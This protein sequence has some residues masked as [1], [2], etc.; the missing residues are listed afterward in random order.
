MRC[1]VQLGELH[2]YLDILEQVHTCSYCVA[3]MHNME[4]IQ[5]PV[6]KAGDADVN[7][8]GQIRSAL[9]AAFTIMNPLVRNNTKRLLIPATTALNL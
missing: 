2:D 8:S 9:I 1:L 7:R 4:I 5:A 3:F 6:S